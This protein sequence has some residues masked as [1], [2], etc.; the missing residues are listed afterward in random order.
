MRKNR[1]I[2]PLVLGIVLALWAGAHTAGVLYGT[3]DIPLHESY[4]GDEPSPVHGALHM[5]DKKSILG[6][7]NE[8]RKSVV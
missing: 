6:L 1:L 4:I 2:I 8:D 5:L 7:R 3:K